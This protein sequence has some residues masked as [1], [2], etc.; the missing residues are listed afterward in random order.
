MC[1]RL[2]CEGSPLR[3]Q[4]Q[5]LIAPK[6]NKQRHIRPANIAGR[7]PYIHADCGFVTRCPE[8]DGRLSQGQTFQC[9]TVIV[10]TDDL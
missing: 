9:I 7:F 3:F 4:W 6:L 1:I 2:I 8:V 5:C 10:M